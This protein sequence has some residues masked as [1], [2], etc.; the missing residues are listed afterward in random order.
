MIRYIYAPPTTIEQVCSADARRLDSAL[1]NLFDSGNSLVNAWNDLLLLEDSYEIEQAL[2]GRPE[3]HTNADN[4][5]VRL[6]M[7]YYVRRLREL[8]IIRA[9]A[10]L[11]AEE[12]HHGNRRQ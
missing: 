2:I 6:N 12:Q 8:W 1:D 3:T 4:T 11:E 10:E 5:N 9:L 7:D